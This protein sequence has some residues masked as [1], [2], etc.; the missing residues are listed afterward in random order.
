M[1]MKKLVPESAQTLRGILRRRG[2]DSGSDIEA[3][4]YL[5]AYSFGEFSSETP[6][7]K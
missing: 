2:G 1:S 3:M 5:I 6:H 7:G 4:A